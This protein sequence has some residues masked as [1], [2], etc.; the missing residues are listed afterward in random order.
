[1]LL[2]IIWSSQCVNCQD[3]AN[4][5]VLLISVVFFYVPL[6]SLLKLRILFFF[7]FVTT[8]CFLSFHILVFHNFVTYIFLI[9]IVFLLVH[10]SFTVYHSEGKCN[11]MRLYEAHYDINQ[12]SGGAMLTAKTVMKVFLLHCDQ[13][14][15][16]Y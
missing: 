7:F 14:D 6:W 3:H 4:T 15:L 2:R 16:I 11:H 13:T 8:H 5:A 9:T 10:H 1:M 12:T